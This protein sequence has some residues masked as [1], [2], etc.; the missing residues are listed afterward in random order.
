[1]KKK[2]SI[3]LAL[4]LLVFCTTNIFADDAII[5]STDFLKSKEDINTV[6]D[7]AAPNVGF[8]LAKKKLVDVVILTDYTGTNLTN[9]ASQLNSLKNSLSA[10]NVD[11][12]YNI[13]DGTN[14]AYAGEALISESPMAIG[15]YVNANYTSFVESYAGIKQDLTV[16]TNNPNIAIDVL[17][18]IKIMRSYHGGYYHHNRYADIPGSSFF[19]VTNSGEMYGWG[20]SSYVISLLPIEYGE[21]SITTPRLF[22]DISDVKDYI[23]NGWY[24]VALKNDGS[25]WYNGELRY[26]PLY[27]TGPVGDPVYYSFKKLPGYS[28]IKQIVNTGNFILALKEDGTVWGQ[29]DNICYSLGNVPSNYNR[30][31]EGYYTW[32]TEM[33][34]VPGLTDVEKIF[35]FKHS[36]FAIK[37]DGTVW[38]WG[39]NYY[40]EILGVP[41]DGESKFYYIENLSYPPYQIYHP[42]TAFCVYNPKKIPGLDGKSISQITCIYNEYKDPIYTVIVKTDGTVW[43]LDS[44]GLSKITKTREQGIDY[45]NFTTYELYPGT[46]LND[47]VYIDSKPSLTAY[48]KKDGTVLIDCYRVYESLSGRKLRYIKTLINNNTG[49]SPT[50]PVYGVS[51][52]KVYEKTLRKGSDRYLL[53]ISKSA[54]NN[55]S[56]GF[57]SYYSFGTLNNSFVEYLGRND[58]SIYAAV[59][60][61]TFDYISDV[62][63]Q[64]VSIRHL[65]NS[66]VREGKLY[67]ISQLSTMLNYINTKY[68]NV[69]PESKITQY[70]VVN[71]DKVEY[72]TFYD[73]GSKDP[74]Y[75]GEWQYTHDPTVFENNNGIIS[76]SGQWRSTPLLT[77]T[78]VGKYDVIYR[79]TDNPKNNIIFSAY[80]KSGD[81]PKMTIYAHRRP[82]A[83]ANVNFTG[84]DGSGKYITSTV[85][86]SYDLDHTSRTDKGIVQENWAWKDIADA[87][88]TPGKLPGLLPPNK[89]YLVRLS[90]MDLEGAW[91]DPYVLAVKTQLS[92]QP[93]T[94]DASPTS[95]DWGNTN[96][97]C[98]VTASDINGDYAYTNYMWSTSPVKP[99][100]GWTKNTSSSFNVTQSTQGSW[101]L[102][103]EAFDAVGNSFY[104][105]RGPYNIDKTPPSGV[106]NPNTHS[107]TNKDVSV[108][109]DPSDTGGSGV[110]QWRYRVSTNNGS[111]YGSWSGYI[112]GDTNGMIVLKDTGSNRMQAEIQDNAGNIGTV[113]SGTYYIDK[114]APVVNANPAT[115]TSYDPITVTLTAADTGGSGLK[116]T[117]YKWTTTT[118]K[119]A[120]GWLIATAGSFSTT[121]SDD[122]SEF[123][124]HVEAFDNAGNSTYRIFGPYKYESLKITG[125]TI[126]G[127]WN[128]WRGQVDMFGKRMTNEPHRFL[129]LERVK[130]NVYTSG[131]ADRV[132][133][134]FSPELEAMQY[135]DIYGNVY[136]YN[137]DYDLNYVYFPQTFALDNTQKDGHIYWEYI[138]PLANSTKSWD[139]RRLRPPYSMTVTAYKG[140][141]SVVYTISDIDITGNIFDLIYIQPVD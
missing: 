79:A 123:Y 138:L 49:I 65:V 67:D 71:E 35:G 4:V 116:Q 58:F 60:A 18:D 77:F 114:I 33:V 85:S 131:Y 122:S 99:T 38:A 63:K 70:V 15:Q 136:D 78:N 125:V 106:F 124:L 98:T 66:S 69:D 115:L 90:V 135:T 28:N 2:V 102:H 89:T 56:G 101:Y 80:R 95:R 34:Q 13:I 6:V 48:L 44:S 132:E 97:T 128:H 54:G 107:W 139:D 103:M 87:G 83:Q 105:M 40:T 117:N 57:G 64:E 17:S 140:E 16:T 27:F 3:F 39:A 37:K 74:I 1:M 134:R 53:C 22:T 31:A 133:I 32:D 55:Y 75:T 25:V 42:K 108:T 129:S 59:P 72:S 5:K 119:P 9:L 109:F 88:W 126:S 50:M 14:K 112:T 10:N 43:K 86:T 62:G 46:P 130:I 113:T 52:N 82:I 19:A 127:Y 61:S 68:A 7:N 96:V 76:F 93:P 11:M 137:R 36:A 84:I 41:S 26:S 23:P 110:K 118:A 73:D 100:S 30:D 120:S 81:T 24:G 94:V 141:K 29:G 121:L 104:R 12:Q 8:S 51:V 111:T 91:S 92:N 20:Y 21:D 45:D 47:I